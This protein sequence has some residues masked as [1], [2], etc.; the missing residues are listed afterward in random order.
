MAIENNERVL[1]IVFIEDAR[2][3]LRIA[4]QQLVVV[5]NGSPYHG[6]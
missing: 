1:I 3:D 2:S 6:C 4:V 5:L